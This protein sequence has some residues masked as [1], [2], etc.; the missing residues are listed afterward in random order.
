LLFLNSGAIEYSLGNRELQKMGGL[1]E[2]M[3]VT[4]NT[5]LI[6]SMSIA[7]IPPFNGFVSKLI[8]ILACIQANR[9][10]LAFCA[11]AGSI[12]TLASFMKVQKYAFFGKSSLKDIKEVPGI[13]RL[14]MIILAVICLMGGLLIL[15]QLKGFLQSAVDVLVSGNAYKESVFWALK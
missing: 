7:G 12:L 14:S 2:K 6:A 10:G 13:M 11:I 4:A 8:I 15:P 9:I 5:N 1:R 3:P